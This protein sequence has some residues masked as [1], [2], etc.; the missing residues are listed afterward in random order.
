[1]KTKIYC[2][3]ATGNSLS[4][5]QKIANGLGDTQIVSIAREFQ[6]TLVPDEQRIGF[7]F[8]V[9]IYGVPSIVQEFVDK[10]DL[11][12][13]KYVFAI[14]T[15]GGTPGATLSTFKKQLRKKKVNLCS[16]FAVREKSGAIGM[17]NPIIS[18]IRRIAGKPAQNTDEQI[19]KIV[20]TVRECKTNRLW[21]SSFFANIIGDILHTMT[22]DI[23]KKADTS[24]WVDQ[25]C[26]LCKMCVRICPRGN[27]QIANDKLNWNHNCEQCFACLHWCPKQAIQIGKGSQGMKRYHNDEVTINQMILRE[28]D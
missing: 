20:E 25:N 13:V 10:L 6:K 4:V 14:A 1:M 27:I 24:F 23:L 7:V 22:R 3:S 26:N 9:Y 28:I 8:P 2:F 16:G 21:T 5:S 12:N 17:G 15:C 19:G 18:I 11:S